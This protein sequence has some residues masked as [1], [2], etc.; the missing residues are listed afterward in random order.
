MTVI[1]SCKGE[2]RVDPGDLVCIVRDGM[3]EGIPT[4]GY[5]A[6]EWYVDDCKQGT[7]ACQ[8]LVRPA[9]VDKVITCVQ[10]YVDKETGDRIALP[11]SNRIPVGRWLRKTRP[12][13]TSCLELG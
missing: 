11:R 12:V 4:E 2:Y 5:F 7:T 8:Y 6:Q 10:T 1:F 9:D 13:C 3:I